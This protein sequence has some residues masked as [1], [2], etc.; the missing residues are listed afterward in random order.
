MRKGLSLQGLQGPLWR[1]MLFHCSGLDLWLCKGGSA[2]A[3]GGPG[4]PATRA[5]S[6]NLPWGLL[7]MLQP[8]RLY[9]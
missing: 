8:P 1:L 4:P 7:K 5:G 6:A 9:P 2:R 3:R